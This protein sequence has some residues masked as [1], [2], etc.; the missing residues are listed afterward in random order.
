[1]RQTGHLGLDE[2]FAGLF[3]QG[4]VTHESYRG[5]D[6]R[7]LYPEEIQREPDGTVRHRDTLEP[8]SV[9]RVEAM[10][11]MKR[12][13]VDPG[14]I[15]AKYG[16]DTA[17]WFVLSDN[18]PDRD[19][20]WTEAGV[21]GCFRFV[22]RLYRYA[23]GSAGAS[24][25][26]PDQLS[27]AALT[28]RQA[29][30]RTIAAVTAAF[31]SFAFNVAVARI[32]E[33]AAAIGEADRS[34]DAIGMEAA[35]HEAVLTA[36]RL[37]APMMPHLAEAMHALLTGDARL[38]VTQPWPVAEAGLTVAHSVVIAVQI[39]GKLRATIEMTPGAPADQVIAAAAAEP[40]VARLLEG[41]RVVK[42]IHVPDRIVNFVVAA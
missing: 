2:P 38:L 35:R 32:Y 5:A 22:Q 24:S 33:L 4:M 30:H 25:A 42:Q 27:P 14:S 19:M 13:T 16:A 29:T 3:T 12:N 6:G 11:K 1:M 10:S 18:P 7:W 39:M 8:V 36:A 9:G 26:W 28:L 21:A 15:I 20:E 31:E 41:R 37:V 23:E 17:R 40:N 34:R